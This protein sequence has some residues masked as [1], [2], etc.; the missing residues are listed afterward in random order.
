MFYN[1][2]ED[3]KKDKYQDSLKIIGSLSNL[4][5]DSDVPYLYYRIAE[6]IFCNSF[7]ANDLSRGDVALD[8]I[9]DDIGIGLKTF[10]E[11]NN[12]SFQK[13]A[14]FNKD[15]CLYE[16]KSPKQLITIVSELRNKRIAFTENLY[17]IDQSIYHCVIRD[18]NRFK[19]HEENMS[20]VD[21]KNI[22]D[23]KKIKN[24]I[25]FNDGVHDYSFN[26]SK[27]TLTKRFITNNPLHEFDV[28]ILANPL[29]DIRN[30]IL[31]NDLFYSSN[32]NIMDT[33]YL[34]LYGKK[35]I[36]YEKSGL[37]QWNAE[38]RVR[39]E[40][41]VY[42]PIPANV[43]KKS[44]SFFPDRDT[45]FNLKLPNGNTLQV[46]V[47]QEGSKALMSYSNRELGKW[48]LRDVLLLAEGELV[49]FDKLQVLGIDSVRIDKID[50]S[51]YEINFASL[52]SYEDFIN[53]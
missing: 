16:D 48:I 27:S 32:C 30:C 29:D 8:A 47:C 18:E 52:N 36:V 49:T 11:G 17:G 6:K 23:V 38:G 37:N 34:P 22:V 31:N 43:H 26:I 9:K 19:I 2:Q 7:S 50:N 28:Q 24:S 33:V 46:K 13:V 1:N 44:P 5:S 40:N 14:E 15:K 39:N 42:I 20:Y 45:P 41:E 53:S 4:F 25:R 35:K 51:T 21:I 12:K 10:L 3:I